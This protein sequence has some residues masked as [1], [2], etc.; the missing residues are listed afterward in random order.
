MRMSSDPPP[1]REFLA[2]RDLATPDGVCFTSPRP[3]FKLPVYS[4]RPPRYQE[5]EC[6]LDTGADVS[7]VPTYVAEAYHFV[8]YDRTAPTVAVGIS[9]NGYVEGR[10]G[11]LTVRIG[12]S[13]TLCHCLYYSSVPPRNLTLGGPRG[14]TCS[15]RDRR[16]CAGGPLG[17]VGCG[18]G[19]TTETTGGGGGGGSA[20]TTRR[21]FSK[22]ASSVAGW[23]HH[24]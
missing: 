11:T 20:T 7:L 17:C 2:A 21:G 16:S 18:G 14:W 10:W 24:S 5:F 6:I 12:K 19:R 13:I 4:G 15:S 22:T 3:E 9:L 8:G 1:I 23:Y